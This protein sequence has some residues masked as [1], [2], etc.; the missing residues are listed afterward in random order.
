[1]KWDYL[2]LQELLQCKKNVMQIIFILCVHL[3]VSLYLMSRFTI[4]MMELH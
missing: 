1:M 2:H 4:R 3:L